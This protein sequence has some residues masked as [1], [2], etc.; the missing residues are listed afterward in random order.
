VGLDNVQG[1]GDVLLPFFRILFGILFENSRAWRAYGRCAPMICR[2]DRETQY[3]GEARIP[4][5]NTFFRDDLAPSRRDV[6]TSGA[7]AAISAAVIPVVP[8]RAAV[9]SGTVSGTVY[10]N[11]SGAPSPSQRSRHCRPV[12]RIWRARA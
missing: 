11:R 9:N 5:G 7:A 2:E 10:E 4:V 12:M 1:S 8:V 3:G 6:V